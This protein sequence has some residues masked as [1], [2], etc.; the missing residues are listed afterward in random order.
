MKR[1]NKDKRI[2]SVEGRA[3]IRIEGRKEEL[4]TEELVFQDERSRRESKEMQMINKNKRM[5][6]WRTGER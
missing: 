2:R 3:E 6:V 1:I 4:K 5:T